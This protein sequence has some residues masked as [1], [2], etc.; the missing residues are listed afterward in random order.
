MLRF[1]VLAGFLPGICLCAG[2]VS[3]Q[4]PVMYLRN[5]VAIAPVSTTVNTP[6]GYRLYVAGGILTE[7]L[8]V[9]D[10]SNTTTWA[11]FVF[12]PTYRL[13]SL[14]S[15]ATYIK[16]H[17]HLPDMPSAREVQRDGIDVADTQRR[18]LQKVEEL[19]LHAIRQ[20]AELARLRREVA[21]LKR[22]DR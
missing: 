11:D 5:A 8:R 15:T 6:T 13:R 18:L 20:E 17:G 22:R 2:L 16:R 21:V 14:P 4:T 1:S 9:A 12:T 19:T 10:R 7:R 3:A